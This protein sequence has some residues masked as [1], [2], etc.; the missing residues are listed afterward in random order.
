MNH[1][2]NEPKDVKSTTAKAAEKPMSPTLVK[3]K[4]AWVQQK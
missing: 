2:Y 4:E 1:V 3:G